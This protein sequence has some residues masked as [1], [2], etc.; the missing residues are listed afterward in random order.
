[1]GLESSYTF[2]TLAFP[3]PA[4]SNAL[5]SSA[6]ITASCLFPLASAA[7][8]VLLQVQVCTLCLLGD[9]TGAQSTQHSMRLYRLYRR[10][11]GRV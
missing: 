5:I 4:H 11:A 3:A 1:M 2:A 10:S 8:A 9:P 6:Q 7:A